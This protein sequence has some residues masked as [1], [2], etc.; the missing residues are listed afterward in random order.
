MLALLPFFGVVTTLWFVNSND[1]GFF[2]TYRKLDKFSL[3]RSE[4]ENDAPKKIID[5]KMNTEKTQ[6]VK[7]PNSNVLCIADI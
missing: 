1:I 4:P 5:S 7:L 3:L 2:N 6:K